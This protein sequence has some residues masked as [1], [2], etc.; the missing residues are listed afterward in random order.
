MPSF[1]IKEAALLIN[2]HLQVATAKKM[3][4]FDYDYSIGENSC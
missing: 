4:Y 2:F 1:H 3:I